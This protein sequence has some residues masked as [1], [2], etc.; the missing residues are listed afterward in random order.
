MDPIEILATVLGLANILLVI[1]RSIWNFPVAMAMVSLFFVLF[2]Q[3]KLYSDAG[4]QLFFL[5]IN[6]YGWWAWSRN[7]AETGVVMVERLG[8]G[9]LAIWAGASLAAIAAWGTMMARYTDA[10]HP[11]WDGAIAM[12]SVAAQI[13]MSRRYLENWYWWIVVNAISIPLYLIKGLALTTGLYAVFLVLAVWGLFEW[14][15]AAQGPAIAKESEPLR[16]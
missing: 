10:S 13:L 5:A 1:R 6:A 9:S 16:I 15:K 12:L 11:Y 14:R 4:L 2:A 7:R 3:A 8:A